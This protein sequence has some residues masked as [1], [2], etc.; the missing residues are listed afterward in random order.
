MGILESGQVNRPTKL[1]VATIRVC[2][3]QPPSLL[4]THGSHVPL[5][6]PPSLVREL[7]CSVR[8]TY[9]QAV[10]VLGSPSEPLFPGTKHGVAQRITTDWSLRV[11]RYTFVRANILALLTARFAGPPRTILLLACRMG[12]TLS[13]RVPDKMA[14]LPQ[15]AWDQLSSDWKRL[16][17][18][19]SSAKHWSQ[20][21]R[22]SVLVGLLCVKLAALS[23][24]RLSLASCYW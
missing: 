7:Q 1:S 21:L 20:I 2:V 3:L 22:E 14:T 15:A 17:V 8:G 16:Q 9:S 4:T 10:A 6:Q 23:L 5:L 19:Q 13:G 24:H 11:M 12:R 18:N